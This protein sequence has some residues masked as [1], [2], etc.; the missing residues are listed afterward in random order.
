MREKIYRAIL[1]TLD[2]EGEP[3]TRKALLELD[4]QGINVAQGHG[5]I[6]QIFNEELRK[7][8]Y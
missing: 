8:R 2:Q 1:N 5:N 3:D 6:Q 7:M 4:K